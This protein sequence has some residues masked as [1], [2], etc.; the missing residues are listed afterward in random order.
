MGDTSNTKAEREKWYHKKLA[1]SFCS[2]LFRTK[3]LAMCL[4]KLSEQKHYRLL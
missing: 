1:C 2:L 3:K 4:K